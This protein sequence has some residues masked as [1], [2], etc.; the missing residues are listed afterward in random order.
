M[1][2]W[3]VITST[4]EAPDFDDCEFLRTGTAVC[5]PSCSK[6]TAGGMPPMAAVQNDGTRSARPGSHAQ[7]SLRL[8]DQGRF[9]RSCRNRSGGHDARHMPKGQPQPSALTAA[10]GH[11]RSN[12]AQVP[13]GPWLAQQNGVSGFGGRVTDSCGLQRSGH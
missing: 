6:I 2:P 10:D 5:A 4:N 1:R 13:Q 7:P 9:W 12:T 3:Q 8:A 11:T